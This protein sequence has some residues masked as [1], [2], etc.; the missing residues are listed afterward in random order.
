MKMNTYVNF[1]GTCTE[2]FQYY[3]KHLGAKVGMMMTHAQLPGSSR[4][5]PEWKD[6]VLHA[7]IEIAGTELAA[8][9]IPNA[10][11]MRSAYLTLSVDSDRE[12]ERIF[13]ALSDGGR[14]LMPMEETFFASRFGQVRDRFG[15]NW[16]ILHERPASR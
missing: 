4:L 14:V 11:P 9:D 8:A 7:R 3:E 6:K 5:G 16:M 15:I 13:T 12:A 2:A 1:A 10:E